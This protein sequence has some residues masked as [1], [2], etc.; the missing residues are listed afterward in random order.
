MSATHD[1]LT[2]LVECLE[3]RSLSREVLQEQLQEVA[4][5]AKREL[6]KGI[7]DEHQK[8]CP[9]EILWSENR[10]RLADL[11]D[12]VMRSYATC[13]ECGAP[14]TLEFNYGPKY[15]RCEAHR[16]TGVFLGSIKEIVPAKR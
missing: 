6:M 2:T 11:V 4:L 7:L 14:A 13:S 12:E 15:Y 16:G 8:R 5:A 10:K 1:P 9:H 3:A